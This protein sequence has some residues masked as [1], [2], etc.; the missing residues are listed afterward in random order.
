MENNKLKNNDEI[1]ECANLIVEMVDFFSG[2][3]AN[4]NPP[5]RS[6]SSS[7][8]LQTAQPRKT[9][10][11]KKR[12]RNN[13]N[14]KNESTKKIKMDSKKE[15]EEINQDNKKNKDELKSNDEENEEEEGSCPVCQIAYRDNNMICCYMCAKWTHIE[16]DGITEKD[17]EELQN[18]RTIEY[19]CPNC[20][21]TQSK[22]LETKK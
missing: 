5:S 3:P 7:S 4:N 9:Q 6:K 2:N 8:K 10:E 16:C 14:K 18:K 1:E 13:E 17:Y 22:W 21:G 15:N 12:T 19:L 11:I 20:R